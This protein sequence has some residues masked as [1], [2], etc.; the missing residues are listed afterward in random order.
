MYSLDNYFTAT[1][2]ASPFLYGASMDTYINNKT[3]THDGI[4]AF[5]VALYRELEKNIPVPFAVW[6]Q[7]VGSGTARDSAHSIVCCG[8]KK[9]TTY[10]LDLWRFNFGWNTSYFNSWFTLRPTNVS[11]YQNQLAPGDY[12]YNRHRQILYRFYPN[13]YYNDFIEVTKNKITF[14]NSGGTDTVLVCSMEY[15][16]ATQEGIKTSLNTWNYNTANIPSWLTIERDTETGVKLYFKANANT[17][18]TK[19][20]SLRVFKTKDNSVYTDVIVT[21]KG[22][23]QEI[24]Y[25]LE[26]GLDYDTQNNYYILAVNHTGYNTEDYVI[27]VSSNTDW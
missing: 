24:V 14:E 5:E 16:T 3:N 2:D 13:E 15:N 21:L 17:G 8:Y 18:T 12:R 10:G 11:Q 27:T 25:T 20:H 9:E 19:T 26:V 1:G 7:Y 22:S 6:G 4:D 23:G